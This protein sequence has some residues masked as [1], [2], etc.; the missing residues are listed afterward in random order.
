MAEKEEGFRN[1][2]RLQGR[3]RGK[4]YGGFKYSQ[5][6][7]IYPRRRLRLGLG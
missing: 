4:R 7:G 3:A 2:L 1:R 5:R 6:L